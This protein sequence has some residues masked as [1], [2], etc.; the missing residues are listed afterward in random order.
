MFSTCVRG[1]VEEACLWPPH[2]TSS[3][4]PA[5]CRCGRASMSSHRELNTV[6]AYS[7][8]FESKWLCGRRRYRPRFCDVSNVLIIASIVYSRSPF[9]TE[10]LRIMHVFFPLTLS[11]SFLLGFS[12]SGSAYIHTL[13]ASTRDD[14]CGRSALRKRGYVRAFMCVRVFACSQPS[15]C[16]V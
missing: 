6:P 13:D 15:G 8:L 7:R 3:H 2:R 12:P 16:R 9:L 11:F 1:C 5:V 10:V 14:S 4:R